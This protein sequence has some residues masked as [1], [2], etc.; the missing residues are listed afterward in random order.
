MPPTPAPGIPN[1][2]ARIKQAEAMLDMARALA[3]REPTPDHAHAVT[4]WEIHY[5]DLLEKKK[6]NP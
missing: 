5:N 2:D 4:R 6:V 1:L 3:K